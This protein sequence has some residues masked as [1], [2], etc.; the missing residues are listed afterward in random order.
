MYYCSYT[1]DSVTQYITYT[2]GDHRVFKCIIK[3]TGT[4]FLRINHIKYKIQ[5]NLAKYD[6]LFYSYRT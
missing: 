1:S 3:Y 4:I 5:R 2:S 6:C